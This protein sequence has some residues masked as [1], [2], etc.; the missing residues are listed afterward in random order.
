MAGLRIGNRERR[1]DLQGC[2]NA[3]LPEKDAKRLAV[4]GK[5]KRR[6]PSRKRG[7]L[8]SVKKL[9]QDKEVRDLII[10]IIRVIIDSLK[11]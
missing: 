3:E 2:P 5:K 1:D 10:K 11:D 9:L 6:K 7:R 4:R 8:N